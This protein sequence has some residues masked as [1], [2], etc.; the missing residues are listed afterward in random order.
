M[1]THRYIIYAT[2]LNVGYRNVHPYN[3]FV[4]LS[5]RLSELFTVR[6]CVAAFANVCICEITKFRETMVGGVHNGPQF[7]MQLDKKA[8]K[9]SLH[10]VSSHFTA[11]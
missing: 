6:V 1:T 10:T 8:D 3:Y 5:E 2:F 9:K 11:A 4:R 7:K